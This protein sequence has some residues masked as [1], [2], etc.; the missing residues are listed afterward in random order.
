MLAHCNFLDCLL[1]RFL[2]DVDCVD[3][4]YYEHRLIEEEKA[5]VERENS[6]ALHTG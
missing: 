5:L 6:Q 4:K 1:R 3:Y 2:F